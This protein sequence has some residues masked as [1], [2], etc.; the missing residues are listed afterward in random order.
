MSEVEAEVRS[1]VRTSPSQTVAKKD[2]REIQ[3]IHTFFTWLSV[4]GKRRTV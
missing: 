1:K 4:T 2:I 3:T